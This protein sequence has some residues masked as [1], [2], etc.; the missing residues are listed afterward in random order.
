MFSEIGGVYYLTKQGSPL[1]Y[2]NRHA[3]QCRYRVITCPV[4]LSAGYFNFLLREGNCVLI[5]EVYKPQL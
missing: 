4:V 2:Y 5:V 3:Y 1:G